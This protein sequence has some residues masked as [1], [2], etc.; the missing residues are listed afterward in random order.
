MNIFSWV[1]WKAFYYYYNIIT[2]TWKNAYQR[3]NQ[4]TNEATSENR[5]DCDT[6]SITKHTIKWSS[7]RWM[8][9]RKMNASDTAAAATACFCMSIRRHTGTDNVILLKFTVVIKR[10][11]HSNTKT[12]CKCQSFVRC[13]RHAAVSNSFW[14][15]DEYIHSL[16]Q[17][18]VNARTLWQNKTLNKD[19]L[20]QK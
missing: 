16:R 1:K 7:N 3:G 17:R 4:A 20:Y 18:S 13:M 6:L 15:C 8:V 12:G 5:C 2:F 14:L 19:L 11:H 10:N 9:Y